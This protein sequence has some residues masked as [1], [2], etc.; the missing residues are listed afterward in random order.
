MKTP[1][2]IDK[3]PLHLNF[4]GCSTSSVMLYPVRPLTP[5]LP[6]L[7]ISS[8]VAFSLPLAPASTPRQKILAV[9]SHYPYQTL[10]SKTPQIT[11][12]L[13]SKPTSIHTPLPSPRDSGTR[14]MPTKTMSACNTKLPTKSYVP[15]DDYY[16]LAAVSSRQ[17][18]VPTR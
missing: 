7:P 15:Y 17:I 6:K 13:I 5:H 11:T 18:H 1:H 9:P 16:L 4:S 8:L 3:R 14:R 12:S 2:Q 10:L